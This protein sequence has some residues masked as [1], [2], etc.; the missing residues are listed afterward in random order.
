[1]E[2]GRWCFTLGNGIPQH[3][4][5]MGPHSTLIMAETGRDGGIGV[6]S[7][8]CVYYTGV[9][10]SLFAAASQVKSMDFSVQLASIV[11]DRKSVV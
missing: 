6:G 1:M 11:L 8:C 3:R 7:V 5:Q 2:G 4:L 10:G 9:E